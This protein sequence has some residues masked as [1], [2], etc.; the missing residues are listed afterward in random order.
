MSQPTYRTS[1]EPFPEY[2]ITNAL[3]FR[4]ARYSPGIWRLGNSR[5]GERSRLL[6]GSG[7]TGQHPRLRPECVVVVI[8]EIVQLRGVGG[9]GEEA[10]GIP[11]RQHVHRARSPDADA[12]HGANIG[13]HSCQR[14]PGHDF[15]PVVACYIG[16]SSLA[17]PAHVELIWRKAERQAM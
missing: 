7:V 15:F 14:M 17:I 1:V 6:G 10:F 12:A 9:P 3:L 8:P 11:P 5:S 4:L 13:L 2:A 16:I